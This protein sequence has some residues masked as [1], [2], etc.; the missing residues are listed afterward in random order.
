[1][2]YSI[3]ALSLLLS[4][5]TSIPVTPKFPDSPGELVSTACP[6]LEKLNEN[7]T[8][9]EISRTVANNYGTYYEC[10]VKVDMWIRWYK[11]QRVI[12]EGVIK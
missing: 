5:C 10:A 8:L 2:K 4:A 6:N 1:M 9:S 3:L 7:P 12:F 11:E